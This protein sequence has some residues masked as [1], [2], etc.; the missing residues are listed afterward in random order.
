MKP[1]LIIDNSPSEQVGDSVDL[2]AWIARGVV[3]Y[4]TGMADDDIDPDVY[5]AVFVHQGNDEEMETAREVFAPRPVFVFSGEWVDSPPP[6]GSVVYL[7]RR[8]FVE[9]LHRALQRYEDS[10]GEAPANL[11]NPEA[12]PVPSNASADDAVSFTEGKADEA[13]LCFPLLRRGDGTVDYLSTLTPLA[14]LEGDHRV[15]VQANYEQGGEGIELV[16]RLRM[17]T[18]L[19]S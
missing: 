6:V 12:A 1:V 9:G 13:S 4:V 17:G 7:S 16:R 10:G 19:V 11:F 3:E 18:F 5:G 2:D 8:E 15:V 14:S